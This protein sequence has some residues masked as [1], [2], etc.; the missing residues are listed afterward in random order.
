MIFHVDKSKRVILLLYVYITIF[1]K[2]QYKLH[3]NVTD[4]YFSYLE[5][6][7]VEFVY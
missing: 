1:I 3:H 6:K 5:F 4:L 7:I 2:S